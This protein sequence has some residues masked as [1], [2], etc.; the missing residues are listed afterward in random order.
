MASSGV[1]PIHARSDL[2]PEDEL[3]MEL[4]VRP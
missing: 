1:D 2:A 3:F 4:V